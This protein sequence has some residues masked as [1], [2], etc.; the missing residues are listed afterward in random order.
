MSDEHDTLKG[1]LGAIGLLILVELMLALL[2]AHTRWAGIALF[3]VLSFIQAA[4]FLLLWYTFRLL[5]K[6]NERLKRLEKDITIH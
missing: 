6:V 5:L 1:P 3:I 4:T 2:A